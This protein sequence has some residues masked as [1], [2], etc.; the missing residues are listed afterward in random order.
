[1]RSTIQNKLMTTTKLTLL[2]SSLLFIFSCE[3]N[4]KEN[5]FKKEIETYLQE[6]IQMQ[7][8]PGLA[9]G[10]IKNGKVV[11]EEYFGKSDLETNATVSENTLFPVYSITKLM[12]S[13]GVFQLIEQHKISLEDDISKHLENLPEHWKHIKIK[14]LLTH[15][16][17]LPDFY[18][19]EGNTSDADIWSRLTNEEMHFETG[20]Q[21]EY[22][23]TNY[24]LLAQI[25]EKVTGTSLDEFIINN[26]F[27]KGTTDIIF[28]SDLSDNSF[29]RASRHEFD[30]EKGGYNISKIYGGKRYH[31]ANGVNITLRELIEWNSRLDKNKLLSDEQKNNM[32]TPFE[33][34]NKRDAFL[35]GW[36]TYSLKGGN[37][38]GFTGGS[39]TGFRKFVQNDLTIIIFTN[40]YKYF[41]PHNDIINRVAGIIDEN[42]RDEKAIIQHEIL[43]AFLTNNIE[44][45]IEKYHLIKANNPE[46]ET[47]I[48]GRSSLSYES[49]LNALGYLVLQKNKVKD[50]IKI[51]EL[52]AA[53]NPKSANCFDSLGEAYY[54]DNQLSLSKQTFEKSLAL[55]PENNNAKR[56]IDLIEQQTNN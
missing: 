46:A 49:T 40:G 3:G 56:M 11:Y 23:Q 41:S 54:A 47:Q 7:Q 17:G 20:N 48:E 32:W 2:L 15:S 34:G 51:L 25:I 39:Q 50:A 14:N 26:Q 24:W 6:Q 44:E 35:H 53:E 52:N 9:L 42:L 21:F 36:H 38:Y 16:S 27:Q 31:A 37:A 45:A 19:T 28:S 18:V 8:I 10:V 22:N 30:N 13:T 12:V 33:F 43:A 29:N 55:N 1:M 5:D 4:R